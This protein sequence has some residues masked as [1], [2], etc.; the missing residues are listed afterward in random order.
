MSQPSHI[1]T[2]AQQMGQFPVQHTAQHDDALQELGPLA[3]GLQRIEATAQEMMLQFHQADNVMQT[4]MQFFQSG[5]A[6]WNGRQRTNF[7]GHDKPFDRTR[8]SCEIGPRINGDPLHTTM[9]IYTHNRIYIQAR[10]RLRVTFP[11]HGREIACDHPF[12][13]EAPSHV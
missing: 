6:E 9:Q 8:G 2:Q 7:I 10:F 12:Q 3:V 4:G 13:T 1:A 5:I 11:Y